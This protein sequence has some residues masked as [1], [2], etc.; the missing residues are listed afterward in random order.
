MTDCAAIPMTSWHVG[1][2]ATMVCE[3][4]AL[5]WDDNDPRRPPCQKLT[6]GRM[7]KAFDEAAEQLERSQRVLVAA[8]DRVNSHHGEL[9]RA[10]LLR[11]GIRLIEKCRDDPEI[12]ARLKG[13]AAAAPKQEEKAAAESVT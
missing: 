1:V 12:M 5:A 2:P 3:I 4:C 10:Q 13:G 7:I 8:G 6:L 9:E 11:A